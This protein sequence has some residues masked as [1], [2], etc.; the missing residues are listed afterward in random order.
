MARLTKHE[1][2]EAEEMYR[3]GYTQRQI[4]EKF[5]C[6]IE[7]VSLH[8]NKVK[9]KGGESVDVVKQEMEAAV[10]RKVKEF[11]DKRASRQIDA[12]ER[13]HTLTTTMVSLFVKEIKEAQAAGKSLSA[14]S[15]HAKALKEAMFALK[16]AREEA[17]TILDIKEDDNGDDMPDLMVST[18]SAEEEDRIRGAKGQSEE[19]EEMDEIHELEENALEDELNAGQE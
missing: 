8:M 17:Y 11:A 15:G 19:E 3:Q 6:R 16:L 5:G 7:T 10:N 1:W 9:V 14:L 4:A 18:M 13:F 2:L 12:K